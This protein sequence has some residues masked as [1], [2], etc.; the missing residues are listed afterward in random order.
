MPDDNESSDEPHLPRLAI[1]NPSSRGPPG[2][3]LEE[4]HT[5][6]VILGL[7]SFPAS[8]QH[9]YPSCRSRSASDASLRLLTLPLGGCLVVRNRG[10]PDSCPEIPERRRRRLPGRR[11]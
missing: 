8:L 11:S 4:F 5:H 9:L 2:N 7:R 3:G 10:P 6:S 1:K